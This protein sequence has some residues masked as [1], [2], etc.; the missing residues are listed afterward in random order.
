[1]EPER[2]RGSGEALSAPEPGRNPPS[3]THSNRETAA[4]RTDTPDNSGCRVRRKCNQLQALF[5]L[6]APAVALALTPLLWWLRVSGEVVGFVWLLAIVCTVLASLIQAVMQ[7]IHDGATFDEGR[8]AGRDED[9][10]YFTRTGEFAWLRIRADNEA[11][12]RE[13]ERFLHDH[14]HLHP[15]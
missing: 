3:P 11:L 8:D 15:L 2:G 9:F 10:D 14:D 7:G 4:M 5:V 6:A 1:M 13:D 12:V